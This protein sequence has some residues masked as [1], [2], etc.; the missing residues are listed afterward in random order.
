MKP[1]I[2]KEVYTMTKAEYI[3]R[4]TELLNRCNDKSLLHLIMRLLEKAFCMEQE[5]EE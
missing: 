4:I 3:E 1:V 5:R 2:N